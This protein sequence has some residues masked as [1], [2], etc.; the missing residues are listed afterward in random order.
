MTASQPNRTSGILWPE[1]STL[2]TITRGPERGYQVMIGV[3]LPSVGSP[4]GSSTVATNETTSAGGG[5]GSHQRSFSSTDVSPDA[6][7]FAVP[8]KTRTRVGWQSLMPSLLS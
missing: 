3:G 7:V 6:L 1:A 8:A 4:F 2:R 5:V